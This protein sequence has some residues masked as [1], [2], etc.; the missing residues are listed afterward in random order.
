MLA[1]RRARREHLIPSLS[2]SSLCNTA[3]PSDWNQAPPCAR[4]RLTSAA[5]PLLPLSWRG[6]RLRTA[7]GLPLTNAALLHSAQ[8]FEETHSVAL[9]ELSGVATDKNNAEAGRLFRRLLKQL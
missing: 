4:P 3:T 1:Q 5:A 7:L 6:R 9:E 8:N 2:A